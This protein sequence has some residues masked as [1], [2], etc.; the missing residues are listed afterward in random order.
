M[1]GTGERVDLGDRPKLRARTEHEIDRCRCT[2]HFSGATVAAGDQLE[3]AL[4]GLTNGTAGAKTLTVATTTDTPT[5]TSTPYT[6]VAGNSITTPTVSISD[7]SAAAG[8][9]SNYVIA[10]GVS[11]TGGMSADAGS[12]VRVPDPRTLTAYPDSRSRP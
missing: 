8:A 10:F 9:K 3:I 1:L 12:R 6:V 11:A 7:P 5:V 2:G 4:H